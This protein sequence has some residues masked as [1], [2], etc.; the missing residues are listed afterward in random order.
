LSNEERAER[1]VLQRIEHHTGFR[2]DD[3]LS[4]DAG[5]APVDVVN[6]ERRRS[7]VGGY[8]FEQLRYG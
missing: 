2:F 4:E 3:A 1:G 7:D 8:L 5:N 6:H